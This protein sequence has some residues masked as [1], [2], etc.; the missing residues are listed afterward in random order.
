MKK[1]RKSSEDSFIPEPPPR[2]PIRLICED[3]NGLYCKLFCQH[4]SDCKAKRR[5]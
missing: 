2:P 4:R 5:H 1:C 3:A